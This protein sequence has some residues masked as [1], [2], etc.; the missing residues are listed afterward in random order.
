MQVLGSGAWIPKTISQMNAVPYLSALSSWLLLL[1]DWSADGWSS[2]CMCVW[3]VQEL[4]YGPMHKILV[5]S[6]WAIHTCL[7]EREATYTNYLG[8]MKRLTMGITASITNVCVTLPPM[9][10]EAITVKCVD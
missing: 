5:L 9:V 8:G 1:H 7:G 4:A 6:M 2:D 3:N 10:V